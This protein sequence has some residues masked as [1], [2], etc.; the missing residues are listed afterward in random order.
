MRSKK[1]TLIIIIAALALALAVAGVLVLHFASRAPVQEGHKRFSITITFPGED[2]R[3]LELNTDEDYLGAALLE[4]GLISGADGEYG[5]MIDAVDGLF[6]D[7]AKRQS[8]IFTK[9]G[10]WVMTGVDTTP[11]YDGDRFEFFILEY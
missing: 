10:E 6:A 7:S 1:N 9:A 8:W 3:V 4:K 11:V 5:F 2:E